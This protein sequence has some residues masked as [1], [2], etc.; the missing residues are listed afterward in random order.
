[1]LAA[2]HYRAGF[3]I[4]NQVGGWGGGGGLG[5]VAR[6]HYSAAVVLP[7]PLLLSNM[8]GRGW[9]ALIYVISRQSEFRCPLTRLRI[10]AVRS[11][12]TQQKTQNGARQG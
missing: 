3:A 6:R 2:L 9:V 1:M 11:L 8:P 12:F 10:R 5:F 7:Q 4:G